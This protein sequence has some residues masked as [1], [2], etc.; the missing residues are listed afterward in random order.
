MPL[1]GSLTRVCVDPN[2]RNYARKLIRSIRCLSSRSPF[3]FMPYRF[4]GVVARER[5]EY[6]DACLRRSPFNIRGENVA[7]RSVKGLAGSLADE[8]EF[9]RWGNRDVGSVEKSLDRDCGDEWRSEEDTRK[10]DTRWWWWRWPFTVGISSRES[11]GFFV[12][13]SDRKFRNFLNEKREESRIMLNFLYG[14]SYRIR[15]LSVEGW[16]WNES[17][18]DSVMS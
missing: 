5:E 17:R 8:R 12:F 2:T 16:K 1:A 4:I 13:N 7:G 15:D 14:I 10:R 9:S 18:R 6:T 11:F 3:D